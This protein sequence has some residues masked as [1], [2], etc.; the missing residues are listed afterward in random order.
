MRIGLS[1]GPASSTSTGLPP[2]AAAVN[3][4]LTSSAVQL[5]LTSTLRSTTD[6]VGVGG[7]NEGIALPAFLDGVA[8]YVDLVHRLAATT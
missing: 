3:A 4:A 6:T 2:R 8:M 1:P 5:L 7:D